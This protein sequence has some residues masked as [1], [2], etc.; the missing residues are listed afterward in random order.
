MKPP[1]ARV[2]NFEFTRFGVTVKDPYRW[3][4]DK[5][6]PKVDDP[7]ILGYL[8]A[9]NAYFEDRMREH[10]MLVEA[11]FEQLKG[12]IKE[13]D[14]SVPYPD[15]DWLY[16]WAF[17]TGGQYRNWYRKP[18]DGSGDAQ[19]ILSE[20]KLAEGKDYFRL[21]SFDVSPDGKLLAYSTD[22]SGSER[23]TLVIRDLATG[24]DLETVSTE[25]LGDTAWAADS[26]SLVWTEAN[27]EWRPNKAFLHRLGE[28]KDKLL[29][30]EKGD[31]WRVG[32]GR[33]QDGKHI[34]LGTGVQVTTEYWLLDAANPAAPMRLV[35]KRKDGV[36]YACDVSGDTLYVLANDDHVNFRV[37]TAP[38]ADPGNWKTLI[39]GSDEVY[40]TDI[41]PFT[42]YLAVEERVAGLDQIRLRFADGSERRVQFPEASYAASLGTNAEPDASELRLAYS[43]M[44]T[45]NTVFDYRVANSE[46]VTRK[47]QQIPSG[48]DASQ[49]ATERLMATARD[50]TK[51]PVS[52]LYKK[53]YKR[54]G[55]MPLHVYGY[56]AYGIAIPPSFSSARLSMVDR[57]FAYA[58]AHVRGGDDLGYQ[59]YLDGK[60]A[61]RENAFHDFI[62]VTKF[63]HT[64]GFGRAGFT[65]ASGG[66][67]GGWLM[68]VV[69]NQAPELWRAV[70][71]HVPFVD[72]VN[73]MLD[74]T[75]PL[76]PGEWP[77]WGDPRTDEVV[78]KRLLHLSP[79]DQT[80]ARSYPAMLITGGLS[81]P[82]VTYWEPAKWAARLRAVKTD[83]NLLLLKINMGAGHG[84]KSGRFDS[85]REVAEEY[86]FIF[87]AFDG[88]LKA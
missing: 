42:S 55:S 83:D 7:E 26:R 88:L 27:A 37:A 9:E 60:L 20:P 32:V 43:S 63:L 13:D 19:L 54:D 66:S 64:Q 58:I 45:P 34:L 53:G 70:V 47:V 11:L 87:A 77:E 82:R 22:T 46:L 49:Y 69:V 25:S 65:S 14:A 59:W 48:Y 52:V 3:L 12:R 30:E 6:Y 85:L 33:S 61:K 56:G 44:V 8:K 18:R 76:T 67:A 51:V 4:R 35:K 68:G 29:Y 41:K 57:G 72:I 50:G 36:R 17:E 74:E 84:G 39:A 2:D 23:F 40:L 16:W 62:D 81:D 80:V 1:V 79:Y 10:S 78:F 38:V 75:L 73:T 24:R 31:G 5:D 28:K 86:A 15:G 21:G 71:A